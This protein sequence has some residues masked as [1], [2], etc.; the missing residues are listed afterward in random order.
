[1]PT[2]DKRLNQ[3]PPLSSLDNADLF[4]VLDVTGSG[5]KVSKRITWEN[6]KASIVA[7]YLPIVDT[8]ALV[9]DP[10]DASKQVRIDAGAIATATTRIITMGDRNVDLAAGGTF[11]EL[12]HNHSATE[13][14]SGTLA[15]ARGGTGQSTY[16][17]GQILIGN[18]TGST[19]A[20]AT[21]TGTSNQVVVTNG[22]GSITLST[23][24]SIGTASNVQFGKVGIGTSPT[25]LLDVLS[26]DG[27]FTSTT[28]EA[29]L[30]F[31]NPNVSHGITNKT[32]ASYGTTIAWITPYAA[33]GG[34][35]TVGINTATNQPAL[36]FDGVHGTSGTVTVP[37][38]Q[39]IASKKAAA[40]AGTQALAA[41]ETAFE[42]K[43]NSSQIA[44]W[45]GSGTFSS[46]SSVGIGFPT[47]PSGGGSP[48]LTLANA[49]N[50]PT[51]MSANTA[52]LVNK[53]GELYAWDASGNV[54]LISPHSVDGPPELYSLTPGLERVTVSSNDYLGRL[55]WINHSNG[56]RKI[57]TYDEFNTRMGLSAGDPDFQERRNW[58]S[59]ESLKLAASVKA[60]K[61]WEAD[62]QSWKK[63][64]DAWRRIPPAM[65]SSPPTIIRP[66]PKAYLPRTN[67]F[68]V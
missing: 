20:K 15:V 6:L 61:E 7:Q 24:Q 32:R 33:T 31:I 57:E 11:A 66:K 55:E 4:Y 36:S 58:E 3:L 14:T 17:N 65:R 62:Y 53:S 39:F 40:G 26:G 30:R 63:E 22:A 59:D 2:G 64:M 60:I 42:F 13:I 25:A 43:N 50:N 54:T 46:L 35:Y 67:P 49:T 51:G 47:H 68:Q 37:V 48:V 16:T 1:M 9:K 10:S 44:A 12:S 56:L 29:S 18:T 5:T 8:T 45:Y 38:V 27:H 52:G 41:T 19:L 21:I 28:G 34:V 23:P